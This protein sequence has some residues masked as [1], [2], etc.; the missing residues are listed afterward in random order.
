MKTIIAQRG[1]PLSPK[2]T[3]YG[4]AIR[5]DYESHKVYEHR[6][7][8]QRYEPRHDGICNTITTVLKDN[9]ILRKA[10]QMSTVLI[11][12]PTEEEKGAINIVKEVDI[13]DQEKGKTIEDYLYT[14]KDGE[15]YGIF[16]LSPRECGRLMGVNDADISKMLAVNSNSQ[17]YKQFGNSIVVPVLMAIFSQLHIKGVTPWN[18]L[19]E[20]E[21]V[22]L[23][24]RTTRDWET[25]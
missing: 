10:E 15:Q 21:R 22:D 7:N 24:E 23:I 3:E 1:R 18:D 17:C 11:K 2:R 19:S 16:K 25:S 13:E 5:K 20:K 14:A 4:K 9:L 8:M 12:E 6:A